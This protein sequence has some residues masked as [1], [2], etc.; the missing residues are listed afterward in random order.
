MCYSF[1]FLLSIS[2]LYT[3]FLTLNS[4]VENGGSQSWHFNS[5]VL[6]PLHICQWG[7]CIISCRYLHR[8]PWC[9]I[10]SVWKA[11]LHINTLS[12][13]HTQQNAGGLALYYNYRLLL[14]IWNTLTHYVTSQLGAKQCICCLLGGHNGSLLKCLLKCYFPICCVLCCGLPVMETPTSFHLLNHRCR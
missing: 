3:H 12:H 9:S 14:Q 1:K 8:F 4:G 11:C 13:T 10:I 6:F 5:M 2:L 7:R